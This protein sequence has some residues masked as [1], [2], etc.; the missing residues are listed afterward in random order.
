MRLAIRVG[1]IACVAAAGLLGA[2]RLDDAVAVFDFHADANYA[3]TFNDRMYPEIDSLPGA[4]PVLEDA[5]LWMPE[6]ASYRVVFGSPDVE[7]GHSNVRYFLDILLWPRAQ[8]AGDASW[9]LCYGCG[10]RTLGPGHEVLSQSDRLLFA[11]KAS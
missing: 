9:V 7:R 2:G 1:V 6:D 8:Q 10:P 3:A 4:A 11:R 5:R